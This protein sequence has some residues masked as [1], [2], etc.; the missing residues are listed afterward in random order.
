[1]PSVWPRAT[2]GTSISERVPIR[3][4]A[5]RSAPKR[6]SSSRYSSGIVRSSSGSESLNTFAICP[7]SSASA[8][9]RRERLEHRLRLRIG[10]DAR[11]PGEHAVAKEIDV[12]GVRQPRHADVRDPRRDLVLVERGREELAGLGE[13]AQAVVGPLP[14]RDLH[15]HR[16]DPDHLA[17]GR[18]H[19]VVAR[20]P[21]APLA[22]L[23]RRVVG[24]LR[25]HDR[26]ARLEHAAVERDEDGRELADDVAEVTADV[27]LRREPVDRGERVVDPDEAELAIPE[28][29]P[30]RGRDEQRVQLRVRLLR[31][32]EEERVVDRERRA[33]RELA[34]ER[35]VE[36]AEA[37]ARLAGPERD[38]PE[39]PA[40]RLERHDDVRHRLQAAVEREVL[41]VDRG[42]R[43]RLLA[44]VLDEVRLAGRE[45]LR[46]R[47]RLVRVRRVALAEL[48]QQLLALGVAVRDHDL[49]QAGRRRPCRR[50]SSRRSAARAA[51]ASAS[52][53]AS[54]SIDAAKTAP[55][56]VEERRPLARGPLGGDVVD[57]VDH[58]LDARRRR[59]RSASSGRATSAPPR[60]AA[61]GSRRSPPRPCRRRARAGSAA[62]RPAA[63]PVLADDHEALRQLRA[64]KPDH[65][66]ARARARAA[67]RPRRSRTRATRP[68]RCAVIPS[69]TLRRTTSS[70]VR[71]DGRRGHDGEV[72][73]RRARR[74][75]V[76]VALGQAK[77]PFRGLRDP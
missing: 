50:C 29:D 48:A 28:A 46:D 52:N 75:R 43:E 35:E 31:G 6:S 38:R 77:R 40:A 56:L 72:S 55:G 23:Q 13:Q 37:P 9:R 14:V 25:V 41:L 68:A 34:R 27:L 73:P 16:A 44:R 26:L 10:G 76:R 39:H 22:H 36:V 71:D 21:V 60:P 61:A 57:D 2:I 32:A 11:D 70:S 18:V 1:M 51:R 24:R 17:V 8:K 7:G 20:E 58:E 59:R 3:S 5:A 69:A 15:D 19:R 42:V 4:N 65:L 54:M 49:A 63:A 33:P 12:A 47:M 30:D 66:L 45:H 67:A 53:V 74:S 64:R 62:R